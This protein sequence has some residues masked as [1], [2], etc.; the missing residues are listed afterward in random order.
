MGLTACG[1]DGDD[2]AQTTTTVD[3]AAERRRM[4]CDTSLKLETVPAPQLDFE[5][6]SPDQQKAE[7][8]KF[9]GEK[10]LPLINEI[11]ALVPQEIGTDATSSSPRPVRSEQ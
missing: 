2:A 8:K 7:A 5:A 6:L 4:Y 1:D 10:I 3:Q 11:E 9:V